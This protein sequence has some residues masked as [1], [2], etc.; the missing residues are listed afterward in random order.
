MPLLSRH[1]R[2]KK[3]WIIS[4]NSSHSVKQTVYYIDSQNHN[5]Y[6]TDDRE[7]SIPMKD[8]KV[9]SQAEKR[10]LDDSM[11][12]K[13]SGGAGEAS[14]MPFACPGCGAQEVYYNPSKS[15][16]FCG[17]CSWKWTLGDNPEQ[18]KIGS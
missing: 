11:L 10:L 17:N 6:E 12:E 7:R 8:A 1:G 3:V 13:V 15:K 18:P 9:T 5:V 4:Q 16:Y 14:L 2:D